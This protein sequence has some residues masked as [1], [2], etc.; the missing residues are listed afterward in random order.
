MAD[1]VILCPIAVEFRAVY[2]LLGNPEEHNDPRLQSCYHTGTVSREGITWKVAL[3][4]SG[5]KIENIKSVTE[6]VIGVLKPK[7]LFLTGVAGGIKDV[8]QGD[9]V[10]ATK[11]Y[12]YESGKETP[13]GFLPRPEVA[14]YSRELLK[15]A[16]SL[17][18]K[19]HHQQKPYQVIFGPIASG[20]KVI[21]SRDSETYRIIETFYSDTV[22]VE[23]EAIG[24]AKAAAETGVQFANIRGISDLLDNKAKSDKEGSQELAGQRAAQFTIDLIKSLPLPAKEVVTAQI[25]KVTYL[26]KQ[27]ALLSYRR[28]KKGELTFR[29][30][31]IELRTKNGK[32]ELKEIRKV[33][34]IAMHG[35]FSP[36]WVM[37]EFKHGESW[38]KIFLSTTNP[39]GLGN[40]FGGSKRLMEDIE[41]HLTSGSQK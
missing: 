22:A 24:F 3:L 9:L 5:P 18:I 6:Q 26:D 38:S 28:P 40:W 33:E 31:G 8:K 20:N 19:Y 4:E 34:H 14:N 21:A 27:A 37:V 2:R 13:S 11:A 32:L 25:H 41:A 36:N 17:S 30:S 39:P 15:L 29:Q 10:V 7:Y 12:G 23:M 1:I 16:Q 35:D